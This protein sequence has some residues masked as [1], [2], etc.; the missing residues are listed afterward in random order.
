[1]LQEETQPSRSIVNKGKEFQR[2]IEFQNILPESQP[3]RSVNKGKEFQ[4]KMKLQN[5]GGR[6]KDPLSM[7]SLKKTIESLTDL[8]N[9][10]D[11]TL[12]DKEALELIIYTLE[13][14]I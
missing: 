2:N 13:D 3:K 1:M 4:R 5:G 12:E 11:D 7:N 6:P 9:R 8:Y 10:K 14:L